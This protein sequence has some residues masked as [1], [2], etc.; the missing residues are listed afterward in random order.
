M[1]D[2]SGG[3]AGRVEP[4]G[5]LGGWA[6]APNTAFGEG[7]TAPTFFGRRPPDIRS[8]QPPDFFGAKTVALARL[9]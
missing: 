5:R 9:C 8:K 7:L 2:P 3:T 1:K 4:Y 6:L